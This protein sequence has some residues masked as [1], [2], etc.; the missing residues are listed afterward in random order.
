MELPQTGK[1]EWF[2][3][4]PSFLRVNNTVASR[5]SPSDQQTRVGS[6]FLHTRALLTLLCKEDVGKKDG[7]GLKGKSGQEKEKKHSIKLGLEP[8]TFTSW[9][10][11]LLVL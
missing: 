6:Q 4:P 3:Y 5:H 2:R 7:V 11:R 9:E 8:R 1:C 10:T